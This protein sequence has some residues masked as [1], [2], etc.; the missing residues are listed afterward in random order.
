MIV[1]TA[2]AIT[3]TQ[4][5]KYLTGNGIQDIKTDPDKSFSLMAISSKALGSMENGTDRSHLPT[6][7]EKNTLDNSELENGQAIGPGYKLLLYFTF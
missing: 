4:M 1:D 6:K 5:E 7:M 2:E 3:S